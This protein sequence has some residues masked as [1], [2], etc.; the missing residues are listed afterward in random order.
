MGFLTET[1]DRLSAVPVCGYRA[2]APAATEPTALA[3]MALIGHGREEQAQPALDWLRQRQNHDGSLGV[4]ETEDQPRWPTSLA[5]LTWLSE[6]VPHQKR[7]KKAITWI[8]DARGRAM[9]TPD[10]IG[11]DTTI[12]AWSWVQDTHSWIE[13]TALHV[14]ALKAFGYCDH[15]RTYNGIRMLKDR[16]L[17]S[18]GCNCGNTIILGQALRP[19]L[20]PTG[21]ALLALANETDE[22]GRIGLSLDY[23]ERQVAR[24]PTTASLA[25]TPQRVH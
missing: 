9:E 20:M 13:P 19:H 15:Q 1:I 21:L 18:G 17:P 10:E 2:N 11:H 5:V 4:S 7:I 3:A 25:S 14:M 16:L 24:Q 22:D 6:P 12:V 8:L 23:A